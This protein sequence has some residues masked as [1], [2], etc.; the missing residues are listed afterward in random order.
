LKIK[1][2]DDKP[3][4]IHT[5]EKP[6][7]H[8]KAPTET[9]IKGR[10]I[11]TVTKGVKPSVRADSQKKYSDSKNRHRLVGAT[12]ER[13]P[14]SNSMRKKGKDT[15]I[16]SAI[17][18]HTSSKDERE[19]IRYREEAKYSQ[20]QSY[21]KSRKD[22]E[23]AIKRKSETIKL[24]GMIGTKEALEQ[25][26]GGEEISDATMLAYQMTKPA[27]HL[28]EAGRRLY[29]NQVRNSKEDRIKRRTEDTSE[30]RTGGKGPAP[31]PKET[32]NY[33][34]RESTA[35]DLEYRKKEYRFKKADKVVKTGGKRVRRGGKGITVTASTGGTGLLAVAAA[36]E[37]N[38]IRQ[39]KQEYRGAAKSRMLQLFLSKLRQEESQDTIG[40][41]LKDIIRMRAILVT[42]HLIRY[43]GMFLLAILALIALI[44]LPLLAVIVI[45]YNSPFAIF[46]P[47]ISSGE[48]TQQVLSAYVQEFNSR[49]NEEVADSS[50]YDSSEK[51]YLNYEGAGAPD[52]T[53]D[54]LAVYMVKYGDGDMATDMTETA[55]EN[56]KKVFDDMCSYEVTTEEE[57]EED[58]DGDTITH[59]RKYVDVTLKT[60]RDMIYLYDFNDEEQKVLVE[61]MKPEYLAL[62][63]YTGSGGNSGETIDA[64]QYQAIVDAVSDANGK[65][66]VG[67]VL[68]KVGYPYSQAYRDTGAYY[69][70]SSLTYYAWKR[71][72]VDISYG[73]ATTAAVEAQYCYDNNLLVEYGNMQPGDLIFYSYGNNGRFENITHVAVY[74]GD[75]KVVEAANERIG[76]VYRPVQGK[77]SIVFIGRPR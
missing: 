75:G 35:K 60:Y 16:S 70:C 18:Y 8:R 29:Q 38:K 52:N 64:S 5:K 7:L 34:H 53:Y 25:M 37:A 47:S 48:T 33:L 77:G 1:R 67:F 42:K 51:R 50:G 72:G 13:K 6:Q 23:A 57:T 55:K 74:V 40:K 58:E 73:G 31:E 45:F 43:V 71:A 44:A 66:V 27:I 62:L 3:M 19:D 24:A 69:D 56:L 12:V 10:N 65:A 32:V 41:T 54:I 28:N 4:V 11:L 61:L 36:G 20:S 26:E 17:R 76:V 68:S 21:Q 22:R 46:F 39:G 2:A 59:I 14:V 30:K 9:K 15:K 63:G 49:V